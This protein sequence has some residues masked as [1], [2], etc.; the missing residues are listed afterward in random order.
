MKH[1]CLSLQK[2]HLCVG[3]IR[4]A[5]SNIPT[6]FLVACACVNVLVNWEEWKDPY[7]RKNFALALLHEVCRKSP[8][9]LGF[10]RWMKNVA[11]GKQRY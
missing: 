5:K 1:G 9:F 11:N 4:I 3:K 7:S 2:L 6:L 10:K 8:T